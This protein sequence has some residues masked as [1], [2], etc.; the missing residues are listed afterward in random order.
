MGRLNEAVAALQEATELAEAISDYVG[1]IW[2]G[3][4][5]G[6]CYLRQGKLEQAVTALEAGQ[7]FYVE[8]PTRGGG[9]GISLYNGLAEAYLLAAEQGDKTEKADWLKKAKCACRDALKQAKA[10]RQV[11]PE[12]IRLQGTYEWLRRKP[13]AARKWW[14]RSLALAEELGQRYDVGMTLLEMGQRLGERAHL[15]RAEAILAEIDAER[16]L[17]RARELLRQRIVDRQL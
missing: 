16:D 10:A 9:V 15:E 11:L 12:T 4:E 6:R 3:G 14:Q 5:L 17:A 1:C 13:A 7:Q 8:H 2:A